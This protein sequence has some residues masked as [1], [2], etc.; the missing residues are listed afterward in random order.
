MLFSEF[1]RYNYDETITS[2][3][4]SRKYDST[5]Y[6]CHSYFR[7]RVY[8]FPYIKIRC[9][10]LYRSLQ[11]IGLLRTLLLLLI[12][13]LVLFG[14]IH[15]S[16]PYIYPLICSLLFFY[17]KKR[18]DDL[19]LKM[20]YQEKRY[21]LYITEYSFLSFTFIVL[22]IYKTYWFDLPLYFIIIFG[23][24]FFNFNL[25]KIRFVS[26]TPFVKGSYECIMSFRVLAFIYILLYVIAIMGLWHKN[27]RLFFV[28]YILIGILFATSFLKIEYLIHTKDYRSFVNLISKKMKQVV[29][30]V[31]MLLLPLSF[32]F[33]L[34]YGISIKIIYYLFII[35]LLSFNSILLKYCWMNKMIVELLFIII[36]LPLF[37]FSIFEV[38]ISLVL[39]ILYLVLL[40]K[41]KQNLNLIFKKYDES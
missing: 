1:L 17:H 32:F 26:Y 22:S 31:F 28:G 18:K 37:V 15:I 9:F 16:K 7:L 40:Y 19:F 8:M 14:I 36:L 13:F 41:A 30:N 23:T 29:V 11:E 2:D 33:I 20:L 27:E 35:L 38:G 3:R 25:K 4:N 10:S 12:S 34:Y 6:L 24:L 21:F 5:F 39:V